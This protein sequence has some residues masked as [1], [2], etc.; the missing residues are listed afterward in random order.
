M[1]GAA[2]AEEILVIILE[3][4]PKRLV[5][6]VTMLGNTWPDGSGD[7][8]PLCTEPEHIGNRRL[9]NSAL[10][11]FPACVS[12]GDYPGLA[13]G[14]QHRRAIGGDNA[15]REARPVGDYCI[16]FG[17][18]IVTP[19]LGDGNRFGGMDLLDAHQPQ[20]GQ[21]RSDRTFRGMVGPAEKSVRDAGKAFG[22]Q[23]FDGLHG[24]N[25]ASG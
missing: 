22:L 13:I 4:A 1:P 17:P 18:R 20:S 12:G 6:L 15:E 24:V 7:P 9:D 14:Q 8:P 11:A 16:R 10:R 5:D 3:P 19:R 25:Q 2:I 23:D 21:N